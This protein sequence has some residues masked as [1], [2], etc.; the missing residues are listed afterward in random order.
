[1][2]KHFDNKLFSQWNVPYFQSRSEDILM[3]NNPIYRMISQS[4]NLLYQKDKL[5]PFDDFLE[6]YTIYFSTRGKKSVKPKVTDVIFTKLGHTVIK[7]ALC[8]SC[9][10]IYNNSSTKKCCENAA[11]T[12]K[13]CT[14]FIDNMMYRETSQFRAQSDSLYDEN[15]VTTSD[16]LM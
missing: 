11:D 7:K 5:Y 8:K 4:E 2:V 14:Y 10:K 15:E 16:D 13:Y 12:N 6:L 1:M 3:E 9:R